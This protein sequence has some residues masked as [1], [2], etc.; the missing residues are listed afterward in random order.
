MSLVGCLPLFAVCCLSVGVV[1]C[2]WSLLLFIDCFVFVVVVAIVRCSCLPCAVKCHSLL[3][4]F[5]VGVWCRFVLLLFVVGWRVLLTVV[6]CWLLLLVVVCC[7]L[8]VCGSGWL[9]RVLC[10]L[11]LF[12]CFVV[13][14]L[15]PGVVVVV[16]F[17][18]VACC[19]CN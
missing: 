14:C 1:G 15:L 17:V 4:L 19:C 2:G 5:A 12:V 11:P 9:F 18:I 13:R 10:L 7:S 6:M 16:M 8:F 3:V